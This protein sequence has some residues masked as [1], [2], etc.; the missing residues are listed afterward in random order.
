MLLG[1]MSSKYKK[2]VAVVSAVIAAVIIVGVVISQPSQQQIEAVKT[3]EKEEGETNIE[4]L[5]IPLR[6]VDGEEITIRDILKNGKPVVLYF[7]T[8]WCPTCRSDLK[9]LK[10]VYSE[11][12]DEV[13]V[14]VVGFDITETTKE[15]RDYAI[16]RGY[17]GEWIF[18]E[19]NGNLI[20]SLK[21]TTMASKLIISPD[22]EIVFSEGYGVVSEE[23]WRSILST[24][25]SMK[26]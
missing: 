3:A 13:E 22:G 11:F 9:N 14:L 17:Y 19:P 18:I 26:A 25:V 2:V 12:K 1:G 16:N 20:T 8:T 24:A 21:I 15:I 6:T 23:E 4:F 10:A 7:F 5:D